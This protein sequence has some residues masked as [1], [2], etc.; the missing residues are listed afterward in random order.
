M[1]SADLAHM[2]MMRLLPLAAAAGEEVRIGPLQT[3]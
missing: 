1:M 2:R 3:S